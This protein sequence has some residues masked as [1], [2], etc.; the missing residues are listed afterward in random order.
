MR[1]IPVRN[2]NAVAYVMD[3]FFR[4]LGER[5]LRWS[6]LLLQNSETL[7]VFQG[8][9]V[10]ALPRRCHGSS[11]E[12]FVRGTQVWAFICR[13]SGRETRAFRPSKPA[14]LVPF[15]AMLNLPASQLFAVLWVGSDCTDRSE[16][17]IRA[18]P[19]AD[20]SLVIHHDEYREMGDVSGAAHGFRSDGSACDARRLRHIA[21]QR[22]P[23]ISLVPEKNWNAGLFQHC[24][25]CSPK[26]GL[27][28]IGMP[29]STHCN[30]VRPHFFCAL[31]NAV[32]N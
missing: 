29:V 2:A 14:S 31:L 6:L 25:R 18:F 12:G 8:S 16:Y 3:C 10:D 23:F 21:K 24:L 27:T 1:S 9:I 30:E 7:T 4:I 13:R 26:N 15:N 28:Q 32:F 11:D 19:V 17:K 5:S 22:Y 20:G